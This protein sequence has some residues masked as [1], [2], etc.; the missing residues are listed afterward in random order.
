MTVLEHQ[1]TPADSYVWTRHGPEPIIAVQVE[2]EDN[3]VYLV[4]VRSVAARPSRRHIPRPSSG[5]QLPMK[6]FEAVCR[7][8]L[9]NLDAERERRSSPNA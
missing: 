3:P 9:R 5:I 7:T 1:V 2:Y 8:F 6:D 4:K